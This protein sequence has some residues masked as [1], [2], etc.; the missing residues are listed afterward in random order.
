M[1]GNTSDQGGRWLA[2]GK[3]LAAAALWLALN[4]LTTDHG[5]K[6]LPDAV[7]RALSLDVYLMGSLLA[8]T[9]LGLLILR[10]L[11]PPARSALGLEARPGVR[12]LVL[13]SL[14]A[15]LI[16]VGALGLGIYVALPTL[17]EEFARGGAQVSRQNLG[18]FGRVV[19]QAPLPI[20]VLWVVVAAPIGEELLFRGALWGA[21]QGL[22][23]AGEE[24]PK[25]ASSAALEGLIEDGAAVVAGR[26]AL[27]WLR[28]GGLA[29]AV[30]AAIFAAMHAGTP[31][32]AGIILVVSSAVL[33][34]ALGL[35]RQ[36]SGGLAAPVALHMFHNALALGHARNWFVSELFPKDFGVPRLL[37]VAG[38]AG[39]VAALLL[40]LLTRGRPAIQ[41][42]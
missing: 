34:L 15:P 38:L 4:R 36:L 9:A 21:L 22:T 24:A 31:G 39:A 42:S 25:S 14:L 16:F 40:A 11:A 33:G 32:G 29:T 5:A 18:E 1:Q 19:R 2:R 23:R 41:S 30:S 20:T 28:G 7:R 35:A 26:A 10:A 17:L 3:P 6:L 27:R 8:S 13:T 37:T 12:S